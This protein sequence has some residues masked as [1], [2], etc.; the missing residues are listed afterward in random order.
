MSYQTR[1][2]FFVTIRSLV[3]SK[4]EVFSLYY[5]HRNL[6]L[7]LDKNNLF[8][9][10]WC[11]NRRGPDVM[12]CRENISNTKRPLSML[13]HVFYGC[14]NKRRRERLFICAFVIFTLPSMMLQGLSILVPKIKYCS[15]DADFAMVIVRLRTTYLAPPPMSIQSSVWPSIL[16]ESMPRPW[17]QENAV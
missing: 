10:L 14:I 11:M 12:K 1:A 5:A 6:V 9:L 2:L 8:W 4:A 17:Y 15:D 13:S 16:G 3:A 7:C